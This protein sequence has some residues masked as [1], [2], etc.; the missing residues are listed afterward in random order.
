[1]ASFKPYTGADG[2]ETWL[3]KVDA[4]KDPKT[5]KRQQLTRRGFKD[6]RTARKACDRL[7]KE[8]E[9]GKTVK[10][11]TLKEHITDFF[12]T[13][14]I[15]K[16]SQGTYN[17]HWI[18]AEKYI[19]PRLGFMKMD[20][21]TVKDIDDFYSGLINDGISPG[22][23]KNIALVISKTFK[24]ALRWNYVLKNVARE[25]EIPSYKPAVVDM[26]SK[27][28][29]SKFLTDTRLEERHALYVLG[30]TSGMRIG[31][32]LALH[33][34]DI[35][36]EKCSVKITKSLKYTKQKGLHLKEPKNRNAYRTIIVSKSTIGALLEH[37]KN[38]LPGVEIVFDN[39]GK[40]TYP[41]EA[42]RKFQE[43]CVKYGIPK[44]RLHSLRHTH[45]SLLLVKFNV[46]V[47]AERLGDNV[48]TVLKTYAHVLPNM[49][50]E[51]AV[52]TEDVYISVD[53]FTKEVINVT[54]ED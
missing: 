10:V 28:Q 47:V 19:I 35:D 26:W 5:G 1:M 38:Q 31:E 49:Q 51:V 14:V 54:T 40:F 25:A 4:G 33:W 15:N 20:K 29:L 45:A 23:V 13:I 42:W 3:F 21:I 18:I 16:I 34:T 41:N 53:N 46:K 48:E 22:Y 39:M 2:K 52:S 6:E 9:D 27:E 8:I 11:P 30:G 50:Q 32:M 44:S 7:I 17:S 24:Q 36:F 43:H 37:K 12:E